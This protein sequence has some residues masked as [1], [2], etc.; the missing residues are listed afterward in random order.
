MKGVR[1]NGGLVGGIGDSLDFHPPILTLPLRQGSEMLTCCDQGML[2]LC[3][4]TVWH[5]GVTRTM[6]FGTP[7]R[8]S[9]TT[10]CAYNTIYKGMPNLSIREWGSKT[11]SASILEWLLAL[12]RDVGDNGV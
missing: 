4:K 5:F 11:G 8:E 10:S 9:S 1:R 2:L 6:P 12:Y 7:R 3:G